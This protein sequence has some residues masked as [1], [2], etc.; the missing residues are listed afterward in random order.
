[1]LVTGLPFPSNVRGV[2]IMLW[3]GDHC[4]QAT[5]MILV[6]ACAPVQSLP[7]QLSH[8]QSINHVNQVL[9]L[10]SHLKDVCKA[11]LEFSCLVSLS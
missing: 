2:E 4:S 8:N 1:M 9:K 3:P 5:L 6:H 11:F 7:D 10:C